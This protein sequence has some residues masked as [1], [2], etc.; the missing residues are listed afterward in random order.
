MADS[1]TIDNLGPEVHQRYIEGTKLLT[2]EELSKFFKTPEVATRTEILETAAKY[3]K[4]DLL[5]GI[6]Q[7]E[8]SPFEEPPNF[9][10]TTNVLTYLLIPSLGS[11]KEI[12]EKLKS[13]KEKE[14]EEGSEEES[15]KEKQRKKLL[16]FALLMKELNEILLEIKRKKEEYHKG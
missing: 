7:R 12:Y 5:W 14:E 6:Q 10:L 11:G 13:I 4:L 15:E 1:K 9:V 3:S 2:E 16:K 8:T